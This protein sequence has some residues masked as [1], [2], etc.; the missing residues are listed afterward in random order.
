[1]SD[2]SYSTAGES[3]GE[4]LIA[5]I[6][7]LPAGLDI[8]LI[9]VDEALKLRQGGHGRGGR[10]KIEKDRAKLISGVKG[11]K[12]LGSPLSIFIA[13]KDSSLESLPPVLTPRPGH[14]DLAGC[15]KVACKDAREILERTSARETAA[16]TAA[17]SVAAQLLKRFGVAVFGAVV[18]LGDVRA[19]PVP[20]KEPV[21][22]LL[23]RREESPVRC[24][25][26]EA[27]S[28]MVAAVDSACA[29][30]DTL[31]GVVEVHAT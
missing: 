20:A 21:S 27:S 17:G 12:T 19:G 29:A 10:Q 9:A 6:E 2:L 24:L 8:D 22:R 15:L 31:G 30:G 1:M 13:N 25:D 26:H 7:G 3:H 28:A 11:G 23:K 4:G 16:R 18:S 5:L 14:G